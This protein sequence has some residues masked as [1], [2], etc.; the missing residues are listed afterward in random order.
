MCEVLNE[1]KTKKESIRTPYVYIVLNVG[2][3]TE[4]EQK[5]DLNKNCS[6][7]VLEIGKSIK[8]RLKNRDKNER[9]KS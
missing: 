3:Q 8:G 7:Q 9:V 5:K 6:F 1:K 2:K 4:M